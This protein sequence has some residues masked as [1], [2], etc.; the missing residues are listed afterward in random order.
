M[1]VSDSVQL[2]LTALATKPNLDTLR[3]TGFGGIKNVG[4]AME[5]T[6]LSKGVKEAI[7]QYKSLSTAKDT[8][9][10]LGPNQ[11]GMLIRHLADKGK[12]KD[13]IEIAKMNVDMNPTDGQQAFMLGY[14]YQKAGQKDLALAA[15]KKALELDPFNAS[16]ME[17]MRWVE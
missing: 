9:Y 10:D 15:Y 11:L 16:A 17:M 3:M 13:A 12:A 4:A 7:D 1:M 2:N 8:T 5:Q 14:A 6:L